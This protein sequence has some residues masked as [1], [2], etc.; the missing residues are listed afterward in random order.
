MRLSHSRPVD[1]QFYCLED[2]YSM[3]LL[4]RLTGT[5]VVS[6]S[7]VLGLPC[8]PSRSPMSSGRRL[9]EGGIRGADGLHLPITA[10]CAD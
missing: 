8:M 10:L 3:A 9:L 2:I 5:L 7:R 1:Q 6:T 4:I